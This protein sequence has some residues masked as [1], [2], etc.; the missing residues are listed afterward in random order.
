M[1]DLAGKHIVITGA[2]TGIGR[3]S[4]TRFVAGGA[5]VSLIARRANLL[6][7]AASELGGT[8]AWAVA[9]V[10]NKADLIAALDQAVAA[11]GPIDG[12]FLNAGIG[13][14]FAP[15]EEYTD[16]AF[17]A[18]MAVNVKGVFWAI[19][20]VL[21]AMKQRRTGAILITGS[22]ASERGM[23]LNAAYVASKHAALGLARAVANEVAEFGVRCN[24]VLPGL[25]DTP[26]LDG[27]PPEAAV[28]MAR[29]VPQG[30]TG[31]PEE[32]AE[33][34]AFLLSDAA[35]HVTAQGWA[36]DGGMLGTMRI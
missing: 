33:V 22:L 26:M 34:A 15:V 13:G 5:R 1:T 28:Q 31:Q 2:S 36:V 17:D 20:H 21:P 14:M 4:A 19:Q 32:L 9:D 6:E 3:A 16:E 8:T 24:C 11:N 10:A 29:A 12:L 27:L 18:V 30:R 7:Q 25:I 23:P 35:S